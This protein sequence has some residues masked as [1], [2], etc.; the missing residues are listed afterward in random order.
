MAGIEPK[1]LLVAITTTA[2]DPPN[3][4]YTYTIVVKVQSTIT[5]QDNRQYFVGVVETPTLTVPPVT[6]QT[7]LSETQPG[8]TTSFTKPATNTGT[9][10][11]VAPTETPGSDPGPA[12]QSNTGP[13]IGA[14]IGC[15]IAGAILGFLI[16]FFIYKKRSQRQSHYA[17]RPTV[18][19]SKVFELPTFDAPHPVAVVEDK[20]SR[21]LLDASS[22]KEIAAELRS[23]GTL[24]QQHVENNYHL[25]PVQADPRALAVSLTQLGVTDSGSVS[26]EMVAKLSLDPRTRQVALQHVISQ[27]LFTSIDVNSR[28]RLSMLP[29]PIAAFL[30][31]IPPLE[32]GEK[33]N[34][35][36][37]QWRAL[38]A[39]ILHPSRSQRTPLPT[40]TAAISPQASGLADALDTFL[41]YFVDENNRFQ[42]KSHLQAVITEYA[43]F[44][45]VLLSQPSEWRLINNAGTAHH[46]GPHGYSAVVCAGLIKVALRDGAPTSS[47][48]QVVAPTTV[49]I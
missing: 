24:V 7:N 12:Q 10:P 37:N 5:G 6:G 46:S 44:G 45:Y 8:K 38:S 15:L 49:M 14:A 11:G 41:A 30:Q 21:F 2:P 23:L 17:S 43:K 28:S 33:N 32:S 18:V 42:Q 16:A 35:S 1:E 36:L 34:E 26:P 20:L 4:V 29:A 13:V 19:E 27:V 9:S 31:S 3:P 22:D 39:F 40:S 48:Q 47:P 25:K